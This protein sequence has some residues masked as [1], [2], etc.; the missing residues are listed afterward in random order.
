M[1]N[2]KKVLASILVGA[3]VFAQPIGNMTLNVVAD[4]DV[5][6]EEFIESEAEAGAETDV[7]NGAETDTDAE[8]IA[9]IDAN[10]DSETDT[11]V[12]GDGQT[13]RDSIPL[14]EYKEDGELLYTITEDTVFSSLTVPEGCMLAID[15][16]T[17][18]VNGEFKLEKNSAVSIFNPKSGNPG[19]LIAGSFTYGENASIAADNAYCLPVINGKVLEVYDTVNGALTCISQD[20]NWVEFVF[21]YI[22]MPN[23]SDG[24][25]RNDFT[26]HLYYGDYTEGQS[27]FEFD[28]F[29]VRGDNN[30]SIEGAKVYIGALTLRNG[31]ELTIANVKEEGETEAH[32]GELKYENIVIENGARLTVGSENCLPEGWILYG[33]DYESEQYFQFTDED[34][35]KINW[36]SFEYTIAEGETS[37]RWLEMLDPN[38][39]GNEDQP[40]DQPG[41][42]QGYNFDRLKSEIEAA[43]FAFGDIYNSE[44]EA[45]DSEKKIYTQIGSAG[46]DGKA[47]F[48][49]L[50]YGIVKSLY[51]DYLIYYEDGGGR[52]QR[53]GKALGLKQLPNDKSSAEY[54]ANYNENIR[55]LF[56]VITM[57]YDQDH[58]QYLKYDNS[59]SESLIFDFLIQLAEVP[60]I[61][62]ANREEYVAR[63]QDLGFDDIDSMNIK[64]KVVLINNPGSQR[65]FIV[66]VGGENYLFRSDDDPT[67]PAKN[68]PSNIYGVEDSRAVVIYEDKLFYD[69][70]GNANVKVYG[71]F[72]TM[73]TDEILSDSSARNSFVAT[74]HGGLFDEGDYYIGGKLAVFKTS[75]VGVGVRAKD[76]D[77]TYTDM[78]YY[79]PD[80]MDVNSY[81][82]LYEIEKLED[83]A[84]FYN[85]DASF[86]VFYGCRD[87]IL[88]PMAVA[89][90][91][92]TANAYTMKDI[93]NQIAECYIDPAISSSAVKVSKLA[94]G[95]FCLTINTDYY[96]NIRVY[97][98]DGSGNVYAI[99]IHRIGVVIQNGRTAG[100]DTHNMP[101][102]HGH[103]DGKVFTEANTP[104]WKS[105]NGWGYVVFATYYYSS[106]DTTSS[107]S[108]DLFVTAQFKDG[109]T[110]SK[111]VSSTFFTAASKIND[112]DE[113][114]VT[115]SCAMDDYLI[116]A[117]TAEDAP[118]SV[119]IIAI[120]KANSEGM[121]QGAI[122]G[123]G[124]GVYKDVHPVD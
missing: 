57:D 26:T 94:G 24:W 44:G 31:G 60:E 78:Q 118:V 107:S 104:A 12:V 102:R 58:P 14:S 106:S 73:N 32:P 23:N 35:Q 79:E 80:F 48:D 13:V 17:V 8:S 113:S 59:T 7:E 124:A 101:I 61:T 87:I 11:E 64:G 38:A 27:S 93:S 40:G 85:F 105:E 30:L 45:Y 68:R 67:V 52:Y 6:A 115:Y 34:Y 33:Y 90:D 122:F 77:S 21:N 84:I 39:G 4:D 10:I 18:T 53:E 96:E 116:Y 70:M 95:A 119:S 16:C 54:I 22:M 121:V 25:Y 117:G 65:Y 66:S 1:K 9:E 50:K 47:M 69:T 111:V 100:D 63:M 109:H 103:L 74:Y 29:E 36:Y 71:N 81:F 51:D 5:E 92:T 86:D 72:T 46:T 43:S 89:E 123:E 88:T 110:E 76:V 49:D 120:P 28:E 99:N 41:D 75:F 19:K 56:N 2:Y 112:S 82:P 91:T 15:G 55:Y 3:M 20:Y 97:F 114:C 62:S 37:G 98:K 108:V 83:P 42:Q